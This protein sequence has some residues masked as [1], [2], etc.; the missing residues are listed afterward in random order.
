MQVDF[1]FSQNTV[2]YI[3]EGVM[4]KTAIKNLKN[5][6]SEKLDK[7]ETINLYLE[8]NGI[9]RFTFNSVFISTLFPNK[10]SNRLKK[11]AIVTNRKWIRALSS[12]ENLITKAEI[13]N[14]TTEKRIDAM[15]WITSD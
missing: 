14:F 5:Q 1:S 15:S 10:D 3:V 8:D 13:K 6:I 2:G 7:F 12:M 9:E 4:D 11:V